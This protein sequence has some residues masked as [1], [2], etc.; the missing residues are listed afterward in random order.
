V[1]DLQGSQAARPRTVSRAAAAACCLLRSILT[2]DIR[3]DIDKDRG[4]SGGGKF[5]TANPK[6]D[7]E[8][9]MYA[10]CPSRA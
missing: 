1:D 6:S 3:Y 5:S 7:V 8:W 4:K 9:R 2:P 10:V